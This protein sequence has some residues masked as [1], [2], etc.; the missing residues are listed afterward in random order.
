[1]NKDLFY[2]YDFYA[3]EQKYP[4][5][6]LAELLGGISS[7]ND[8]IMPFISNVADLLYKS[9]KAGENAEVK[10]VD[11]P[12]VDKELE[13]ILEDNPLYT[14][15]K[16]HSEK[17]LSEFVFN[18][19][20]SRIFKK[21]GHYNET[22]VIQNYIHSW[23]E[24]K[25]ALNI[26][27][28]SRFSSL[29]VL[30]S[31]LDK[32]EMLHGFYADLI[33]NLPIDWVL[34]KKEEW[35]NINVSPDKLLDAVRTYDKEFFNG[36]ENSIS[37]LP[38]ENLWGF[39]QEATRHSDYIMLNHEFSFISSVLIRKDISLWIEFW[40]NLKLPIIQDCVFI[41][42]LNFSPKEYL[43]LASKLTDEKTVVKSN[44]KVLLLI[45]A[46]NYFE[47]SNK[48]TERFSIY[49]DSERKNERNEQFFEKGIEKQIEWIE[50]KKKNYEN[51]IQSLKKAL[52][53]SEIEDW[54]FSYR[55]RINSR[56]YKPND[57]YN[58]EIKLLTETY[59]KKSVEFLSLDLQSFNL[60]KFN[61]YVEVI[62]H[63][64]DKNILSTLLEAITNYISS[65]KFF[66][67]RT[68]TEPYWSA[69][70]SLGFIISQQD[71]PIQ[72][73][74]ELI[75]KFKTIHQGWNPSKIDFSPLVKESFI[76]SGVALLFENESGFKGRNEKESFFKGLT[77]HILTQDRFSHIDSSEYY[78]MPLHLLFL[79]ANQIFSEHKE[80]FEQELIENYDNLYSLLNILSNDK[81]PLLDQSK[82]QLQKRLDKE[83]LFLKRQYS[84]RNQKDKVHELERMLETLKL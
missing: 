12:N 48:L 37:K 53:N 9:I 55:P 3:L 42:S 36:Y 39:A 30:K 44:L 69:L 41:S 14:S 61:F 19:F 49:E 34:N 5:R 28:D 77:N 56:Q 78:Q 10:D 81:F 4:E 7:L 21:D 6:K 66:W 1:M 31:L 76:C 32:T 46:H 62:R 24:N 79:V 25:L 50:T 70:K 60:Q 35:V 73:A 38:K 45:V 23:L 75:N 51:I 40:D 65:D 67:D 84:N 72:T 83:F 43:Q 47:A 20:L 64:E 17:S 27:Q 15:Y 33:E 22:H 82:E 13:K 74:K 29:V 26:A 2:K 52:S 80:F 57:I 18:K 59:K 71:N 58:S 8:S 63:K 68:Y 11:A 16:A 54:I